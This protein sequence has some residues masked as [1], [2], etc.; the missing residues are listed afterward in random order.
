MM[1][2]YKAAA[3]IAI[4]G[5][6]TFFTRSFPFIFFGKKQPSNVVLFLGEYI[7][8]VIIS[9]LLVYCLKVIDFT[10]G[11]HGLSELISV[12][13]V[14]AL[15]LWKRNALISIFGGTALYM[16]FTQTGILVF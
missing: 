8:P 12:F 13:V 9:I 2:V 6:I 15:H 16:I 5:I 1:T 7:P 4:M 14:V 10:K 3:A 11:S